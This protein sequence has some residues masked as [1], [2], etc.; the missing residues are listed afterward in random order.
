MK[1]EMQSVESSNLAAV[2]HDA[3]TNTLRVEFNNGQVYD[4]HGVSQQ[5]Y[6]ALMGSESKGK[7]LNA[8][9]KSQFAFTKVS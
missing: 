7:F 3:N 6:D 2:G 4:Y 1:I 5:Q 8:V 9:I